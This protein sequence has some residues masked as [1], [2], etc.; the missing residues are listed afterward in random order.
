VARAAPSIAMSRATIQG[1]LTEL[2][3]MI[4]VGVVPGPA[5]RWQ[6]KL[7]AIFRQLTG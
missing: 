4:Q 3:R 6:G 2:G 7:I 1:M 5:R